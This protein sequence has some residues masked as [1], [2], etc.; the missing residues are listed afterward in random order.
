VSLAFSPDSKYLA[1][2]SGAPDWMLHYWTW[3][4]SKIM[5]STKTSNPTNTAVINQ[6]CIL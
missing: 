1:A 2:Q 5:A 6:V 4:K 3:E